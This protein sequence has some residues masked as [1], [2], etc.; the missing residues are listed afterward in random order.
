MPVIIFDLKLKKLH[1][2]QTYLKLFNYSF[3]RL[4]TDCLIH[5][6]TIEENIAAKEIKKCV[7]NNIKMK[8]HFINMA[9]LCLE[10]L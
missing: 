1:N 2:N 7:K 9:K 5:A 10:L 3:A 6:I 8:K 4:F